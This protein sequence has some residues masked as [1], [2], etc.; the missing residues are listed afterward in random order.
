MKKERIT[1]GEILI[2]I[3]AIVFYVTLDVNIVGYFLP[4]LKGQYVLLLS[5][6]VMIFGYA[7]NRDFKIE[8]GLN[9]YQIY[10]LLFALFTFVSG[11]WAFD[12]SLTVKWGS[13]FIGNFVMM[14]VIFWCIHDIDS[15]DTLLEIVMISGY[16]II[17]YYIFIYGPSYFIKML[18]LSSISISDRLTNDV[19]NA[20]TLGMH[21]AYSIIIE[22]YFL[23]YKKK[24]WV[25]GIPFALIS[26]IVLALSESRKALI[27]V[28]LGPL[29]I[30]ICK[31]YDNKNFFKS[32]LKLLGIL[33]SFLIIIVF[34]SQIPVF[35]AMNE[36][37]QFIWNYISGKGEVGLSINQRSDLFSIGLDIFKRHPIIGIGIDNAK[38]VVE[39]RMGIKN[40]YLHN[41]YI[42]MLADGGIIGFLFYYW[43][44]ISLTLNY[45]K[46]RDLE[47]S[48]YVICLV[49][50]IIFLLM[51][52][53][54]VSYLSKTTYFQVMIL[55]IFIVGQ[56]KRFK[57][58]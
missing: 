10:I 39:Q 9:S 47:N 57:E 32:I 2:Y 3:S 1:I 33:I 17:V 42:E 56:K 52:M 23:M 49:L 15:I 16:V 12:S 50:L 31:N 25:V 53:F 55:Y 34:I 45:I 22:L 37:M 6:I 13:D 19:M 7:I 40:Y 24:H 54:M 35:S 46:C 21:A 14:S 11:L 51:D 27:I 8:I 29:A 44:Y 58:W 36:R 38:I 43:L 28:I 26:L 48:E 18:R 20:N 30:L 5:L 41:N 4:M